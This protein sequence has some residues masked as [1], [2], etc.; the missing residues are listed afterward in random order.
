[1]ER[2]EKARLTALEASL[3]SEF[4]EQRRRAAAKAATDAAAQVEKARPAAKT[5]NFGR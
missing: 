1:M 2:E 3:K 5:R 4:A